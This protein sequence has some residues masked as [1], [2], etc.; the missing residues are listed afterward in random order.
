MGGPSI[1]YETDIL[2]WSE[3]QASL[4]R[5]IAAGER[6]PAND[7]PDW[8]NIIEEVESVG[9]Y[10]LHSVQSLLTQALLHWLKQQAWPAS[11]DVPHWR[12][13]ERAFRRQAS[14]RYTPSMRQKLDV[15]RLY[16]DALA[17]LPDWNDDV[18]AEPVPETCPFALDELLTDLS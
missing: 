17:H 7:I 13:E 8:A 1:D 2:E 6:L 12:R 3:H 15:V 9:R 10:Q 18:A 5:H 14:D 4:L 16:A 11:R